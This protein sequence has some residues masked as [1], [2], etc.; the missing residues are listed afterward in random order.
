MAATSQRNPVAVFVS[1]EVPLTRM[2]WL[3]G[4]VAVFAAGI[5]LGG[6]G[7]ISPSLQ[8]AWAVLLLIYILAWYIGLWR[9]ADRYAGPAVW[10]WAAR[11]VV[12]MPFIGILLTLVLSAGSMSGPQGGSGQ[13]Q[14]QTTRQPA[15]PS[16]DVAEEPAPQVTSGA[17]SPD[18]P[19]KD[20]NYG[21]N[22][23]VAALPGAQQAAESAKADHYRQIYA[24]HPDADTL[25]TSAEFRQWLSSNPKFQQ[26][27]VT[28]ST[29]DVISM[30]SAFKQRAQTRQYK[31]D[32]ETM[33]RNEAAAEAL[34]RRNQLAYPR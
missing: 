34:D 9:S 29:Q 3:H 27:A 25:F 30:F 28:G 15:T 21:A 8:Q 12:V 23:T 16:M 20:P 33:R 18:N 14:V 4:V 17:V 6:L 1:G 19:F 7:G 24:A 13:F 10:K 32:A 5:T 26:T 11:A 2:F 22:D 31:V